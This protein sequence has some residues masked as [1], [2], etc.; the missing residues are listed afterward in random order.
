MGIA[1]KIAQ[2]WTETKNIWKR[3]M[4][5]GMFLS[6][7]VEIEGLRNLLSV[8]AETASIISLSSLL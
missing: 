2:L 6:S 3:L 7:L 5:E 8:E 1:L 4:Y